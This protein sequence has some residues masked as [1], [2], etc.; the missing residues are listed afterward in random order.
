MARRSRFPE[1]KP[2]DR[3]LLRAAV[4]PGPQAR[5][6]WDEWFAGVELDDLPFDE[7]RL[8]PRV[9]A[10]LAAQGAGDCAPPR[11]R[12]KY[13]WVWTANQLRCHAVAPALRALAEAGIPT[14][15]LKGAALLASER[16]PWGAREMGDVDILVP[17]GR[18]VDAA[19]ALDAAGWV[20]QGGVTP[21]F[22]AR[23]LVLRRHSWNYARI[24]PHDNLD[25]H[26]HAFEVVRDAGVDAELFRHARR[27]RFGEVELLALDDTDQALHL[28]EHASHGEPAHRLAWIAD[29]AG[30]LDHV[31]GDQ[32]AHRARELGVHD[33][34]GEALDI[35]APALG[36][37]SPQR[38]A[39]ALTRSRSGA[40]ERLLAVTENGS[41]GGRSFPRLSELAR[42]AAVHGVVARHPLRTAAEVLR[43]RVE[44]A[45]CA[46]PALSVALALAGRPRRVEVAAMRGLG[47]LARPPARRA[48]RP[49]EWV[50]LTT[51]CALDGVAGAGW[52][53][54]MPDGVWTDGTDARLALDTTVPRGRPLV[55]EFRFGDDAYRSPNPRAVV[56]VNG[57]PLAEWQFGTD[58]EYTPAR[59]DIPAWLGDWCRPIDVAIR[60]RQ[61]FV[62]AE[63]DRGPGDAQPS[64]QLRAVRVLEG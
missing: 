21:E 50:E 23:R 33:L 57:R 12:G 8:L 49:G 43:R 3:L 39:D 47:P 4:V 51:A 48:L 59:L 17:T 34:A 25:L 37:A 64:V 27:V 41:I 29:V 63:R 6:A 61:P 20:A 53:W 1:P 55:L 32:L 15:L 14:V 56:L 22:L 46:R 26:W 31:D 24:A 2:R 38:A 40:R 11:L 13:R 10:N 18:E 54:P 58:S 30:V 28:I 5:A 45:L 19:R 36:T 35:L 7:A 44:P 9:Y 60:P 42:A 16:C 52:S 62:P